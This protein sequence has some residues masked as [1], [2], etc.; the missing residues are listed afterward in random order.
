MAAHVSENRP[1]YCPYGHGLGL[2]RIL[3]G[4]MPCDCDRAADLDRAVS[5]YAQLAAVTGL[6]VGGSDGARAAGRLQA[7]SGNIAA[8]LERAAAGSR[9]DELAD[10]V[11]GLAEYWR[12]TGFTQPALV[13]IAEHAIEAHGTT[14][15]QA[16]T[17]Q[18]L[19]DLAGDTS[20][21]DGARAQYKRAL[22][23]HQQIGDV[24]GEADCIKGLG[25]I[26]LRKSDHDGARV[27]YERALALYQQAGGVLGE[28]T[29]ISPWGAEMRSGLASI[30]GGRSGSWPDD[31]VLPVSARVPT[32]D[33]ADLASPRRRRQGT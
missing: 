29:C 24:L 11:Y 16:R 4:W 21:H 5:H 7:D 2:G 28:A 22:P 31:A 30:T 32:D 27:R 9:I 6:Q 26:A 17:W 33:P 14:I 10:G 8:M 19:G 25:N 12:L 23:L 20:D 13:K 18:A 1:S 15:Q 3:V